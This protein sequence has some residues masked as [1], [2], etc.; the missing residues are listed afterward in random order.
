MQEKTEKI[1]KFAII[2]G[3]SAKVQK[4][5]RII[6]TPSLI[7]PGLSG[8]SMKTEGNSFDTVLLRSDIRFN[9]GKL[10]FTLKCQSHETSA[11]LHLSSIEGHLI[12]CGYSRQW[13]KFLI[14]ITD[15]NSRGRTLSDAGKLDDYD[16]DTEIHFQITVK[17]SQ[18]SLSIN[19]IYLCSANIS[20]INTPIE[21]FIESAGECEISNIVKHDSGSKP[22]A[23]VVMQFSKEYDELYDDVIRPV[24]ENLGYECIRADDINTSTPILYDI[25]QSIKD[26]SVVVADITPDNPNVFYE[27]GYSH[28]I[29]KPTILLCDR[30]RVTSLPFDIKGFRTLFYENT[31]AGKEKVVIGLTKF[32]N[33][34]NPTV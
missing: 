25:I 9:S 14:T 5:G 19:D 17:G 28:A 34:S 12:S 2:R 33:A 1:T 8:M 29:E 23:F 26:S 31:I 18:V 21:L 3:N 6:Y 4:D 24:T 13:K 7:Q 11:L 15:D 16:L 32:L 10:E 20:I 30:K 27:V 22:S